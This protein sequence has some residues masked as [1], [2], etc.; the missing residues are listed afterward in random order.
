MTS[1]PALPPE[2]HAEPAP[3]PRPPRSRGRP[4]RARVTAR[5]ALA[6]AVLALGLGILIGYIARGG[7][8][9]AKPVTLQRDLP[10]VTVTVPAR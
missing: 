3:T 2:E 10:V 9:P 4:R 1:R 8:S 7:S 5:L 6:A